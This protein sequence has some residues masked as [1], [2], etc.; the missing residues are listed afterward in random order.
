M[1]VTSFVGAVIASNS[2]SDGSMFSL[3]LAAKSAY[4]AVAHRVERK[5]FGVCVRCPSTV[6]VAFYI[7][8]AEAWKGSV[9]P[10]FDGL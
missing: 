5:P 7:L 9:V 10:F 8:H 3:A 4:A 2:S 6:A 1:M